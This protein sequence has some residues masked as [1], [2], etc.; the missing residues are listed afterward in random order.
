MID[1][2]A[3]VKDQEHDRRREANAN[4]PLRTPARTH[5]ANGSRQQ[6]P[7]LS[8]HLPAGASLRKT[9]PRSVVVGRGGCDLV[10]RLPLCRTCPAGFTRDRGGSP[11]GG[12]PTAILELGGG[13]P[14]PARLRDAPACRRDRTL[15][16]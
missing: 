11:T 2:L 12:K 6:W 4:R 16:G 14:V 9:W 8:R 5:P 10:H 15:A 13:H 7:A 1:E 3:H